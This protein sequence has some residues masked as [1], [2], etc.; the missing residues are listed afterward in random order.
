LRDLRKASSAGGLPQQPERRAS[1]ESFFIAAGSSLAASDWN[2]RTMPDRQ[3]RQTLIVP[4]S[5]S[6]DALQNTLGASA[7]QAVT[8]AEHA[9]KIFTRQLA[10]QHAGSDFTGLNVRQFFSC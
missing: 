1:H 2:D 9:M 5:L 3:S 10:A 6:L 4:C 7:S 8:Y